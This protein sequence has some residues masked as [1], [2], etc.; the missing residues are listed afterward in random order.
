M[1]KIHQYA[2][3]CAPIPSQEAAIKLLERAS[4]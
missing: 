4:S 1:M 3:L 2:I